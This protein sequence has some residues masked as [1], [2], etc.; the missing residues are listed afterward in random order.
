[1]VVTLLVE[2]EVQVDLFIGTVFRYRHKPFDD[3]RIGDPGDDKGGN[4]AGF[5]LCLVVG[6]LW[7]RETS[8]DG[9]NGG[10]SG[11]SPGPRI[12]F[13]ITT[14][15]K[16]RCIQ[17]NSIWQPDMIWSFWLTYI[18]SPVEDL[19]T[20]IIIIKAHLS[21]MAV[22]LLQTPPDKHKIFQLD[23]HLQ[24]TN[25]ETMM[26]G[27]GGRELQVATRWKTRLLVRYGIAH[28]CNL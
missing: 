28:K 24:D 1:M 6:R 11:Y 2:V 21:Q 19:E 22:Q 27:S 18:N 16:S 5:S 15:S 3:N 26:I 10:G 13:W 17:S 9:G 14:R 20:Q 25:L 7:Q 12:C 23:I 4:T 8:Y